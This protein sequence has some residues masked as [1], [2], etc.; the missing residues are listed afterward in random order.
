M[1]EA[2]RLGE[3]SGS[4][5]VTWNVSCPGIRKLQ[6]VLSVYILYVNGFKWFSIGLVFKYTNHWV[7]QRGAGCIGEH[8]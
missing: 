8:T 2:L 7:L 5:V 3:E 4:A 6:N 1:W